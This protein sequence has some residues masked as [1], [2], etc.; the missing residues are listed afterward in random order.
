LG[1]CLA[2]VFAVP[3]WAQRPGFLAKRDPQHVRLLCYN[4]NWDAIFADDDPLNH[5]YRGHNGQGAFVRV[6]R[7]INP[8]VICIQEINPQREP[9]K[10]CST[11][12]I[13]RCPSTRTTTSASGT[14]ISGATT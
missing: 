5:K 12:W 7:V 14:A 4:V 6:L 10:T 11:F 13:G 9:S 2:V 3:C 8:D 1:F